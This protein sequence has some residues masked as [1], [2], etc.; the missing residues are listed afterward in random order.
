MA[1]SGNYYL[2]NNI[3]CSSSNPNYPDDGSLENTYSEDGFDPIG[4]GSSFTGYL[5]GR[6]YVVDSLYI[7]KPTENNVGLFSILEDAEI[8]DLGLLNSTV[9]GNNEVGILSGKINNT[10]ISSSYSK[11]LANGINE[12]GGLIGNCYYTIVNDSYANG[13]IDGSLY[14]GGLI[15]MFVGGEINNTYA[16]G[17][18]TGKNIL[19]GIV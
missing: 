17:T 4:K 3:D 10:I 6:G 13:N 9:T 14:V 7:N 5:N 15:G 19:G 12:V 18:V 16:T 8:E 1:L 2:N 11:G